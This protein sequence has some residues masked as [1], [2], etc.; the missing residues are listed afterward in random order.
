MSRL[1]FVPTLLILLAA[2]P[3]LPAQSDPA[4]GR[5]IQPNAKVLISVDWKRIRQSALGTTVTEKWIK[6]ESGPIAGLPGLEFL[7][8]IDR[9]VL[10]SP[11]GNGKDAT[12]QDAPI[13]ILAAGHFDL[14][15]VRNALAKFGAKAQM[16]NSTP[17]YRP[18][19]KDGKDM[20]IVLLDAQ[21]ILIGDAAS[22]FNALEH[23]AF[24]APAPAENSILSRASQM[25][26][27]YDAWMIVSDPEELGNNH[28][29]D[30]FAQGQFGEP[31]RAVEAGVSLRTGFAAEVK[32]QF[33]DE[34][35][36]AKLVSEMDKFLKLMLMGKPGNADLAELGKKLKISAEGP[37]AKIALRLTPQELEKNTQILASFRKQPATPPVGTLAT[38]QPLVRATPQEPRQEE[39]K[40]IRIEGLDGGPRE[41]PYDR[42]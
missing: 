40:V 38:A 8:D 16:F 1:Y 5:F 9:L 42:P 32:V 14:G 29:T 6:S 22:V 17:V 12:P 27:N 2:T 23:N 28:L 19:G 39:K 21:N 24:S 20:A 7:N 4:L 36:A 18:Q 41:I 25:D 31:V 35:A 34:K 30:L 10:S 33:E 26:T 15:E 3:K 11:G 37:N 13:L